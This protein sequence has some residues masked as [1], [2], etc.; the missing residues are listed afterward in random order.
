MDEQGTKGSMDGTAPLDAAIRWRMR[1]DAHGNDTRTLRAFT[2]W[3]EARPENQ[4]AFALGETLL[5][6]VEAAL[7]MT[8]WR[9]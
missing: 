8:P 9:A 7:T 4:R 5:H 6:T 3:L 2:T 1:L